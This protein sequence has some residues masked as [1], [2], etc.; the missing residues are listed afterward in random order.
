MK[1]G[2]YQERVSAELVEEAT[3]LLYDTTFSICTFGWFRGRLIRK[4][5]LL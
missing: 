3:T 4:V 5:R 2:E 1:I